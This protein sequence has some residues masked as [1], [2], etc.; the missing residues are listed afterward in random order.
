MIVCCFPFLLFSPVEGK[1]LVGALDMGG[2][3]TQMIFYSPKIS[4]SGMTK[5]PIS[6]DD[7][8]SH[9]WLN[10]GAERMLEKVLHHAA[11]SRVHFQEVVTDLTGESSSN[12]KDI[13]PYPC[14]FDNYLLPYNDTVMFRGTGNPTDCKRLIRNVLWPHGPCSEQE[15]M[16]PS[17]HPLEF[18]DDLSMEETVDP[19]YLDGVEHPPIQGSFYGMSVYFFAMDCVRH[20]GDSGIEKW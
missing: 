19:C 18:D 1:D 7:F 9:S 11:S 16:P 12:I 13:I 10:F 6:P 2:S 14:T 17:Q 5:G 4:E 15:R 3:S 20:H 8:W